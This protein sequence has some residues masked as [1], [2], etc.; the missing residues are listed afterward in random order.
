VTRAVAAVRG[1]RLNGDLASVRAFVLF[2]GHPRSGHSLVGALLDAH[3]DMLIAHELDALKYVE[4]GFGRSSL[5]ALLVRHE[6]ARVAGGHVSGSGY[7]YA[8]PGQWQGRYRHLE[9]IGDKKGSRSTLRLEERPDLIDRLAASIDVPMR[10]IQVVRNPYDNIATMARRA[11]GRSLGEHIEKY[12]REAA[13]VDRLVDGL[14]AE[15]FHRLHL[16]DLI[17]DPRGELSRLCRFLGVDAPSDY[18]DACAG[19]VF[20]APRRTR[21]DAPW[22]PALLDSVARRA[23]AHSWL[24]RYDADRLRS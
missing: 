21:D 23:G 14:D 18:L 4:A 20:D 6:R 15:A 11:P 3:P 12:F 10:I 2:I 24:A 17:A 7:V 8:V 16:E 1:R 5:Y 9:V 22:T 19:I 13:T